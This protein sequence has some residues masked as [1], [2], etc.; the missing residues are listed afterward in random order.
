[1]KCVYLLGAGFTRAVYGKKALLT[2][3][4]MSKIDI[5]QF[6]TLTPEEKQLS[7]EQFITLLDLKCLNENQSNEKLSTIREYTINKI[8]ELFDVTN[9]SIDDLKNYPLLEQFIKHIKGKTTILTLNY[10]CILDQGLYLS[11][12]WH[13]MTGYGFHAFPGNS[14]EIECKKN[15]NNIV[16][17]KLHGSC[18]FHNTKGS[19]N[20]PIIEIDKQIFLN[21]NS[22]LNTRNMPSV[23]GP[24]ILV[25]SYIKKFSNGMFRLWR[26]GI[27]VLTDAEKLVIIGCSLRDEDTFLRYA[28]YHF[29]TNED[30]E[31]FY[32]DIVDES[33]EKC[34][35]IKNKILSLVGYPD[36]QSVRTFCGLEKYLNNNELLTSH[37]S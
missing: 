32:I 5:S 4:I 30:V 7:V 13:P 36:K 1:M 24:H 23:Q 37:Y 21:I 31:K 11:G 9:L 12:R 16:L 34:E 22:T 14:E 2:D 3:E 25:M 33:Q 20:Y 17:L 8:I 28:L 6:P 19:N 15:L 18:N 26:K 27:L 10:D 35:K 29:G